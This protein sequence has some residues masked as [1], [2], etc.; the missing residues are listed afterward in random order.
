MVLNGIKD[1]ILKYKFVIITILVSI[2]V[3]LYLLNIESDKL[4]KLEKEKQE[5]MERNK[6]IT[7]NYN[8]V[9]GRLTKKQ[10]KL[11]EEQNIL[12]DSIFI[13]KEEKIKLIK[14]IENINNYEEF[15]KT[16][17]FESDLD[18][19]VD[20]LNDKYIKGTK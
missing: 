13:L 11:K 14:D 16:K 20:K 17:Q 4:Q 19:I 3:I 12:K 18:V 8:I 2:F 6:R 1:F 10:E 9:I 5:L 7:E 15:K